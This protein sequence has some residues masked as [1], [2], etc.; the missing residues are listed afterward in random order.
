MN[1]SGYY[2]ILER[3]T[4]DLNDD[5]ACNRVTFG[6]VTSYD[7]TKETITPCVH[8]IP[9]QTTFLANTVQVAFQLWSYERL[10]EYK[11]GEDQVIDV[12]QG[13]DNRQNALDTTLS[14]LMRVLAPYQG[15]TIQLTSTDATMNP[16]PTFLPIY[17]EGNSGVCGWLGT[18]TFEFNPNVDKCD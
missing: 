7:R 17:E 12:R 16:L 4:K 3:L 13:F 5:F 2:E 9:D 11:V 14:I 8:I 18:V 1:F 6:D 10:A 15:R